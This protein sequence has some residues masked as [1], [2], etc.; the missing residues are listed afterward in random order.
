[1][2]K[3][4]NKNTKCGLYTRTFSIQMYTI[5]HILNGKN[6]STQIKGI[7]I[8]G[9]IS[10]NSTKKQVKK[11]KKKMV[12]KHP[13]AIQIVLLLGLVVVMVSVAQMVGAI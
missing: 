5:L 7:H 1:M 4:N 13:Y 3:L 2:Q 9:T 6:V 8:F 12:K 10:S 11:R